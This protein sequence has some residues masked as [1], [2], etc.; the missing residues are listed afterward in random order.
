MM[1]VHPAR[2]NLSDGSLEAR[3]REDSVGLRSPP[4]FLSRVALLRQR[5]H[6]SIR[7]GACQ[8]DSEVIV[9]EEILDETCER[10]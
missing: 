2:S 6:V 8:L 7:K 3:E 10:G 5:G 1:T 9:L 4:S